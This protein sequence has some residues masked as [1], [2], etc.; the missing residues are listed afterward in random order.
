M[1]AH[2]LLSDG[3]WQS[4]TAKIHPAGFVERGRPKCPFCWVLVSVLF[5]KQHTSC[6][7]K[8]KST[9]AENSG[10]LFLETSSGHRTVKFSPTLCV[11]SRVPRSPW[12]QGELHRGVA[13]PLYTSAIVLCRSKTFE[14]VLCRVAH[15]PCS[16]PHRCSESQIAT[17][18][19]KTVSPE[20]QSAL[21]QKRVLSTRYCLRLVM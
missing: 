1:P 18:H 19:E 15:G 4:W 10:A 8:R 11:M 7:W 13:A 3:C 14:R 21:T 5:P 20:A 2:L 9:C 6:C 16:R 17:V 12:L